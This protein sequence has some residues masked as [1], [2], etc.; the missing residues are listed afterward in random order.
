MPGIE[1]VQ[2]KTGRGSQ[3]G[4]MIVIRGEWEAW[5][6]PQSGHWHSECHHWCSISFSLL[7]SI[8]QPKSTLAEHLVEEESRI[9]K[10]KRVTRPV[11]KR[12]TL[13][14]VCTGVCYRWKGEASNTQKAHAMFCLGQ[15]DNGFAGP[16]H[17]KGR[18]GGKSKN[19]LLRKTQV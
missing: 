5:L 10:Q 17:R 4:R 11:F 19:N 16:C 1:C 7:S 13:Q 18:S 14:V 6:P 3:G 2:W 8:G 9:H 12:S 15:C